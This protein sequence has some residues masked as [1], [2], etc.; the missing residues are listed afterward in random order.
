MIQIF[1]T[2]VNK[3]MPKAFKFF[4]LQRS[5]R[6]PIRSFSS[7]IDRRAQIA[8]PFNHDRLA[9]QTIAYLSTRSLTFLN[10]S[11]LLQRGEG[12]LKT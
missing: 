7:L 6:F 5:L 11:Y 3:E 2:K 9:S 12:K 4:K 10:N 8:Y 1:T